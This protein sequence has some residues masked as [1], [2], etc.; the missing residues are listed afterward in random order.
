MQVSPLYYP[1]SIPIFFL[2]LLFIFEYYAIYVKI[3]TMYTLTHTHTQT[4]HTHT[5]IHTHN[6]HTPT[7]KHTHTHTHTYTHTHID[8]YEFAYRCIELDFW[9]GR[10]DDQEPIITHGKAMCT[11]I[12]FKVWCICMQFFKLCVCSS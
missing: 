8:T 2:I 10:G 3:T 9:D 11:D 6:I 12:L 4:Q 7:H 1:S 5:H